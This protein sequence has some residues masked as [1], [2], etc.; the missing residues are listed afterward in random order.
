MPSPNGFRLLT[1]SNGEEALDVYQLHYEQIG[2]VL[3]ERNLKG[4]SGKKVLLALK[5][6]QP[7]RHR[8]PVQWLRSE[9]SH[10]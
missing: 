4:M 9:D 1:A 2:L 7:K 8:G 5:C 6:D 3:L 10:E